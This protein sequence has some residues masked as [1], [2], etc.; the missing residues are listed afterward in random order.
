MFHVKHR[1][2]EAELL[3][4][5]AG[6]IPVALTADQAALLLAH[7]DLVLEAAETTNLTA[8]RE[9]EQALVDH[10]VDSLA[11][12]PLVDAGPHGE[13]V[14][15]GS[16]AGYP[17][18]PLAIACGRRVT[19]VESTG[20][21]AEFLRRAVETLELEDVGVEGV[22]AEELADRRHEKYAIAVARAVSGLASLT[23]LA[24]PL[25]KRDGELLAMK[26]EVAPEELRRGDEAATLVGMQRVEVVP[27]KTPGRVAVRHAVVYSRTGEPAVHLPR[28]PGRAQR[29]PLGERGGRGAP[30]V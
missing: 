15:I 8:I 7:L 1:N 14:D 11:L 27:L 29:R 18:I 4:A 12:V 23:E 19:L 13:L 20:K 5:L 25:L 24:A 3:T 30:P 16:G 6:M 28:R 10:V 17:G 2:R 9:R 22:R 26:A 21:K